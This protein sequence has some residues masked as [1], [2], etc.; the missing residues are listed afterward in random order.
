MQQL[1]NVVI[2]PYLA[3]TYI[4]SYYLSVKQFWAAI[5]QQAEQRSTIRKV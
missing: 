5:R 2:T 4:L 3:Y 1:F